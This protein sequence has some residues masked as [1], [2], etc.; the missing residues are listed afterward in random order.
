MALVWLEDGTFEAFE[1]AAQGGPLEPESPPQ[2]V[3]VAEDL[4][5]GPVRTIE[6]ESTLEQ[7][8]AMM[9]EQHFR[10]LPVVD[11]LCLVGVLSERDL[12]RARS[13]S[14]WHQQKVQQWMSSRILAAHPKAPIAEI[15]RLMVEYKISCVPLVASDR[16]LEG[17]LTTQD[18]L[19][20]IAYH[21]PV[22]IWI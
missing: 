7:A 10:H 20:A 1:M 4:V 8:R 15:A 11:D 13:S 21:A 5:R 17:L 12:L 2:R 19:A 9:M 6:R 18:L 16:S 22:E 14:D 3:V